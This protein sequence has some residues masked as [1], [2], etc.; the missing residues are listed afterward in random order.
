M[1][2]EDN[3]PMTG[4]WLFQRHIYLHRTRLIYIRRGCLTHVTS[5]FADQYQELVAIILGGTCFCFVV[6]GGDVHC[7][8][9][10]L[11]M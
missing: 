8:D 6:C 11:L 1:F 9:P 4:R 2:V 5:E 3:T 7:I 10:E